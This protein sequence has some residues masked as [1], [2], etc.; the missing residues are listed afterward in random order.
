MDERSA[1]QVNLEKRTR[2]FPFSTDTGS[3]RPMST[4]TAILEPD[5]DGSLHLPLPPELRHRKVR[6][7]AK[8]EAADETGRAVPLARPEMLRQRKEALVALRAL[9]GLKDVIPDPMAWQRQPRK[10]SGPDRE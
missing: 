7:E 9:G 3:F 1:A 4:I 2:R 8:L 10:P 6:V 5:A